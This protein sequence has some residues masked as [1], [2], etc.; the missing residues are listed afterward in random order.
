MWAGEGGGLHRLHDSLYFVLEDDGT[1]T[2]EG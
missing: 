1:V 2:V